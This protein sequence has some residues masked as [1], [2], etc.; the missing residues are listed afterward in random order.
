MTGLRLK[1]VYFEGLTA[2]TVPAY[3]E[4][5]AVLK[6]NQVKEIPVLLKHLDVAFRLKAEGAR[7]MEKEI[8]EILDAHLERV[9]SLGAPGWLLMTGDLAEVRPLDDT[10]SLAAAEPRKAD[11]ATMK[12]REDAMDRPALQDVPQAI[13]PNFN[14]Q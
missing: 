5:A 6:E 8:Q 11:A 12:A 7:A 13:L 9:A 4:K 3:R 2:E 14:G 10:G 1:A